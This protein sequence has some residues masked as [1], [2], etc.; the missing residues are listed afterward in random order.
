[1]IDQAEKATETVETSKE[2]TKPEQSVLAG[3]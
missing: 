3:V 1:M 2:G